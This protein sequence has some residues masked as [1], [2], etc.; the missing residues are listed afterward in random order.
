MMLD[1]DDFKRVNDVC[2][3]REGDQVLGHFADV[4]RS[5]VRGSDTVCRVGGEEFA[6]ILPSC[7]SVHALGLGARLREALAQSPVESTGEITISVGVALGPEHAMNARELI[8]CAES[9]MMTAKARGKDRIVVFDDA[10]AERPDDESGTRDVRSIAHLKMLQSLARKLNRLNDVAEIGEAIVDELRI[11]IDYHNCIV[12]LLDGEQLT[13]VAVRGQL[14]SEDVDR[15]VFSLGV[16]LTGHVAQTGKPML[17]PNVRESEI[18]LQLAESV[19]DE[20]LASVPLRYGQRVIGVITLAKLGVGQF[21]EDDLRLLEVLAGHASVALENARLYGSLRR[22]ADNAKAWL[23][24]ADAVSEAR[25]VDDIAGETVRT[26]A[27]LM[28][29]SQVSLWLEDQHA[30]NYRCIAETGYAEDPS[31]AQLVK[32]RPGRA[33]SATLVDGRKTPFLLEADELQRI[34]ANE[35]RGIEMKAAGDRPAPAR[36]RHP[37]LDR[38]PRSEGRARPLQRGAPAPPRGSLLPRV[39]RAAED[40]PPPLRAGERRGRGCAARVL[41]PAGRGG[42]AG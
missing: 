6:V 14:E 33:A 30:A 4:L 34:F 11:L 19:G 26:V 28:E 20:S 38:R 39:G 23:E 7:S 27:R 40:R 36:L 3:H 42:H 25:S 5:T 9:A 35:L 18:C 16:G 32:I 31:A 8:A 15:L 1:I 24:F 41:A 17:V 21:D 29:T 22:E 37:R 12:Y 10:A 13:P 2:G